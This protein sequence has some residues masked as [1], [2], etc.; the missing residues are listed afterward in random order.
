MWLQGVGY[1]DLKRAVVGYFDLGRDCRRE[2]ARATEE[3][4]GKVWR[5][6]LAECG[7]MVG[8]CLVEMG[9]LS[10][11]RRHFKSLKRGREDEALDARLAL[12]CLKLGDVEGARMYL[13][14]A[15]EEGEGKDRGNGVMRPLITMAEG[16]YEDAVEEWRALRGGRWDTIAT[17]NAAVCLLYAGKLE[18]V[19]YIIFLQPIYIYP[20][21]TP[22]SSLTPSQP[23]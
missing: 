21:T 11:A 5:K 20:P 2:I 19:S 8:N 14:A 7:I 9:D 3:E 15:G 6:R 10:G 1:G 16:R 12:I 22:L 18:E 13:G 17:Q 23:P 4:E